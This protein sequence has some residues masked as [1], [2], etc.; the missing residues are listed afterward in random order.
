MTTGGGADGLIGSYADVLNDRFGYT[1]VPTAEYPV[2]TRIFPADYVEAAYEQ[3]NYYA[4]ADVQALELY[5]EVSNIAYSYSGNTYPALPSN[6]VTYSNFVI[7]DLDSWGAQMWG[8]L[9]ANGSDWVSHDLGAIP[10]GTVAD[11]RVKGRPVLWTQKP[12]TLAGDPASSV[13]CGTTGACFSPS[14]DATGS[15]LRSDPVR[16]IPRTDCP[17]ARHAE[18]ARILRLAGSDVGGLDQPASGSFRRS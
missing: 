12:V 17:A 10:A 2:A 6:G 4:A 14:Y 9:A 8:G 7:S 16:P 13:Y 1:P 5:A 18:P 3:Y 11:L 15:L